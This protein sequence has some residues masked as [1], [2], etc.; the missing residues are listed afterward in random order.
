MATFAERLRELR[1]AANLTQEG[2]A[3]S[4]DV[5]IGSIRDYEQGRREPNMRALFKVV[6]ALGVS[7]EVFAE[8]FGA[9]LPSGPDPEPTPPAGPAPS[10]EQD[11]G[12]PQEQP[13][14][15]KRRRGP[16]ALAA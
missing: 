11:Q 9:G 10:A 6:K 8:C 7:C 4:C 13:V 15:P 2:L 14:K 5:S 12:Q 1:E 3:R 16:R